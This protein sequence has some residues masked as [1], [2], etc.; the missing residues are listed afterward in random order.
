MTVCSGER[1]V[2]DGGDGEEG[3][4][5]RRA[6]AV[7]VVLDDQ[8]GVT[9]ESHPV[10]GHRPVWPCLAPVARPPVSLLVF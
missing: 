3:E 4:R 7:V 2:G 9:G 1:C 10:T 5:E 6:R 8:D